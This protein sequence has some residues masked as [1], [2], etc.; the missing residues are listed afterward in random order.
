[1]LC[2]FWLKIWSTACTEGWACSFFKAG[3]SCHQKTDQVT[4]FKFWNQVLMKD[5]GSLKS[6]KPNTEP[7]RNGSHKG[8]GLLSYFTL[9]KIGFGFRKTEICISLLLKYFF[10]P[11]V[12]I[13]DQ[14]FL[15]AIRFGLLS[16]L[17][18]WHLM[19]LTSISNL[20]RL[21]S[22]SNHPKMLAKCS[23]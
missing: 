8:G 14:L 6:T 22:T 3:V 23:R 4:I 12:H 9:V 11:A 16:L 15:G 1:M 21:T 7:Y 2:L 5:E 17:R 13:S 20:T 10:C 19:R 18:I